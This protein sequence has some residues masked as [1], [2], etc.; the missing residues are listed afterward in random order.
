MPEF[1]R[2]GGAF[3]RR[4]WPL[5]LFAVLSLFVLVDYD[6]PAMRRAALA[7]LLGGL[8]CLKRFGLDHCFWIY[9]LAAVLAVLPGISLN[10]VKRVRAD[11][12]LYIFDTE[13]I[14]LLLT[15]LRGMLLAIP[16]SVFF[17]KRARSFSVVWKV[18]VCVLF[19][20]LAIEPVFWGLAVMILLPFV[21]CP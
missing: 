6:T 10:D 7:G 16:F 11:W 14:W 5:C 3:L 17:V 13:F 18:P 15:T 19:L 1:V 8:F 21:P 4:E 12:Q 2:R 20:I 9:L